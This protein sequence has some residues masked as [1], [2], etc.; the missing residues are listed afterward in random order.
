MYGL[1]GDTFLRGSEV[2]DPVQSIFFLLT[3]NPNNYDG[4]EDVSA[5]ALHLNPCLWVAT[6]ARHIMGVGPVPTSVD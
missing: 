5:R 2:A 1:P 6:I 3:R 4:L